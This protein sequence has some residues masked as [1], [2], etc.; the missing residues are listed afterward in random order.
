MHT[1]HRAKTLGA[2]T[3]AAAVA[4]LAACGGGGGDDTPALSVTYSP[5]AV[6]Q[7]FTQHFDRNYV[8]DTSPQDVHVTATFSS[9]P[10]DFLYVR[11]TMPDPVVHDPVVI[12][13]VDGSTTRFDVYFVPD[14][15]LAGGTYTGTVGMELCRNADCS[16]RI[17]VSGGLDYTFHVTPGMK[18][19]LDIDGQRVTNDGGA[20]AGTKQTTMFADVPNGALLQ[21]NSTVPVEWTVG[22]PGYGYRRC[23]LDNT[24]SIEQSAMTATAL[25]L[26]VTH[27]ASDSPCTLNVSFVAAN[28]DNATYSLDVLND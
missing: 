15:M 11:L 25:T 8:D 4:A 6:E 19:D 12:A 27:Q 17:P 3:V 26:R 28:G 14:T 5:T 10:P 23:E 22:E 2:V 18:V 1:H 21:F 16:S 20:V 7:S 9:A 13:P 24:V